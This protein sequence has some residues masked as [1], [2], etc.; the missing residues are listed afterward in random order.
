M[1][2]E[3]QLLPPEMRRAKIDDMKVFLETVRENGENLLWSGVPD[4]SVFK[5]KMSVSGVI[6]LLWLIIIGAIMPIVM[7]V[8]RSQDEP[9]SRQVTI[10][11]LIVFL[12]LLIAGLAMFLKSIRST[13]GAFRKIYAVT[14]KRFMAVEKTGK[15]LTVRSQVYITGIEIRAYETKPGI[16]TLAIMTP[17][18]VDPKTDNESAKEVYKRLGAGLI[19]LEGI[20]NVFEVEKILLGAKRDL[21]GEP[22]TD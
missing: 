7:K 5:Q 10:A 8:V 11:I 21:L 14:D 15:Y 4:P 9:V 3:K 22:E 6:G 1:Q 20:E 17:D 18:L 19:L 13:K 12:P 16:G 2:I